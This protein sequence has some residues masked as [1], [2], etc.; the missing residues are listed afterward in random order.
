MASDWWS[1]GVIL[2]DI[3]TRMASDW[4]SMG[5]ILYD[6]F[7]RMAS[8]WWS[9]GVILYDIF[10]R[11]TSFMS[12]TAEELLFYERRIIYIFHDCCSFI[13]L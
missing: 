5:V 10:T 1:M 9:V 3:F 6:I 12:S 4:W 8:D 2:Y 13:V 11:M 7:T